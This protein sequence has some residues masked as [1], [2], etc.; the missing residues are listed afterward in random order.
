MNYVVNEGAEQLVLGLRLFAMNWMSTAPSEYMGWSRGRE[1]LLGYDE[2]PRVEQ[3]QW[4]VSVFVSKRRGESCLSWPSDNTVR[5]KY[6]QQTRTSHQ[7]PLPHRR[8]LKPVPKLLSS[9]IT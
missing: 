6:H 8:R 1:G 9:K 3:S 7:Q 2:T 5:N 4:G